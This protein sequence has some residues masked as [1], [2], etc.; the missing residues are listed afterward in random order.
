MRTIRVSTEVFATIWKARLPGENSEGA[1]LARLLGV[2]DD[3]SSG[4]RR[5]RD[6]LSKTDEESEWLAEP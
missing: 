4:N 2:H 6:P 5:K 3:G 1:I